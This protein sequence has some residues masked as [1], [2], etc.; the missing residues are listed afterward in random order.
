MSGARSVEI[1]RSL[2]E[3]PGRLRSSGSTASCGRSPRGITETAQR[4]GGCVGAWMFLM[5]GIILIGSAGVI[6]LAELRLPAEGEKAKAVQPEITWREI[7]VV[8]AHAL[9]AVWLLLRFD[10]V[11]A[12]RRGWRR[13]AEQK[14]RE[15]AKIE[16]AKIV[17]LLAP[18]EEQRRWWASLLLR[19]S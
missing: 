5:L 17:G 19:R 15:Q 4:H 14:E 11:F 18:S 16:A 6:I 7:G 1:S 2:Q 13:G 3:L 12:R 8:I 9:I 10:L